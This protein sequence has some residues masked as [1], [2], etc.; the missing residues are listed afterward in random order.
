M[1]RRS[2][3]CNHV[4]CRLPDSAEEITLDN[5]ID[6]FPPGWAETDEYGGKDQRKENRK[7]A[8]KFWWWTARICVSQLWFMTKTFIQGNKYGK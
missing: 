6:P 2:L 5:K 8:I 1:A 4:F 7:A 3:L